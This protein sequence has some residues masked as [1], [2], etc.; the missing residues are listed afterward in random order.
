MKNKVYLL[1]L[2]QLWLSMNFAFAE[3][4]T[5]VVSP[6]ARVEGSFI[7]LG[8][9]A[10]I[11][12]DDSAGVDR[13]RQ[14]KLGN[15][16]A[17]GNNVVLTKELLGMRLAATGSDFTGISWTVP[18]L[19]TVTAN[20]QTLSRQTIIDKVVAAIEQQAGLRVN[21]KNLSIDALGNIQDSIVPVGKLT[22]NISLPYGIHYSGSTNVVAVINVNGQFVTKIT[23]PCAVKRYD[24][25][26]VAAVPITAGEILTLDKLRLERMD[27][28]KLGT[29]YFT[30]MKKVIG[31]MTRRALTPG[32][33]VMDAMVNKPILIKR[34]SLVTLVARIGSM[35][36]T[37]KGQAMQDGIEGQRIRIK[38]VNSSKVI[39]G[40]VLDENTVQVLTYKSVSS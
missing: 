32:M 11:T 16:P 3:G 17:P 30:E 34:G 1:L 36:I 40:K 21:D 27:T 20:F 7:T 5:V 8:Q 24:Q 38:N 23:I 22:V 12:G 25:V 37:T 28:G 6:S 39:S 26:A 18:E 9:I 4:I 31:L 15:A 19:V 14:L 13:L 29:G 35:E 10:E 2:L 33:V